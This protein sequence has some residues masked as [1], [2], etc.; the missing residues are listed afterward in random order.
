M[1]ETEKLIQTSEYWMETIQNELYRQ[2][3]KYMD[4]KGINQ[5]ELAKEL[6]VTKGYVSQVLNGNF[7]YT[8]NKLIDLSLAIGVVPD[9]EFKSF[10]EYLKSERNKHSVTEVNLSENMF[11]VIKGGDKK[12]EVSEQS[13]GK[14]ISLSNT[15]TNQFT[16]ITEK[17]G[18]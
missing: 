8:L 18:S 15:G 11:L 13:T 17:T 9:I 7:N 5:T 3:K 16:P 2:V 6:N 14:I 1:L 4:E 12:Y 10:D